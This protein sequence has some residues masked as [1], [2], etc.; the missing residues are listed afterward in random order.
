MVKHATLSTLG[1]STLLEEISQSRN[2]LSQA[3]ARLI[4]H[5]PVMEVQLAP[6]SVL[7]TERLDR[8]RGMRSTPPLNTSAV[9][10]VFL[11]GVGARLL[12]GPVFRGLALACMAAAVRP[13]L[14]RMARE[15]GYVGGSQD[16]ESA[17]RN[18]LN[19]NHHSAPRRR[20]PQ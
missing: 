9:A 1:N 16:R 12:A 13:A 19:Q 17:N 11:L 5:P 6:G 2:G 3:L 10:A 7:A 15:D 20:D 14:A 4:D 18:Q 8:A